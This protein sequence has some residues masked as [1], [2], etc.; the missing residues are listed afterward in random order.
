LGTKTGLSVQ[1]NKEKYSLVSLMSIDAEILN[2]V[3]AD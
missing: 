1:Q 3:L 2:E